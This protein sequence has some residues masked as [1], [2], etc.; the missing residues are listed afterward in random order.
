MCGQPAIYERYLMMYK[1]VL[2]TRSFNERP[3]MKIDVRAVRE[4]Y[5]VTPWSSTNAAS[6]LE[7]HCSLPRKPR[8]I[9][10]TS[11]TGRCID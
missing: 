6:Y 9:L 8:E 11:R 7:C 2:S 3:A 5:E 4:R 10:C 1:S